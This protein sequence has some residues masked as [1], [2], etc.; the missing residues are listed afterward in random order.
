MIDLGEAQIFKRHM[1]QARNGV[2]R[3]DAA[4]SY[5]L[6]NLRREEASM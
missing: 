3:A 1:P 5:F 2:V 6:S 4:L